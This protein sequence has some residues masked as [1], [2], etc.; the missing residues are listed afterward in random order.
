MQTPST[1]HHYNLHSSEIEGR[2]SRSPSAVHADQQPPQ[3]RWNS[4]PSGCCQFIRLFTFCSR[5]VCGVR[6][7]AART[8]CICCCCC[9]RCESTSAGASSRRCARRWRSSRIRCSGPTSATTSTTTRPASISSTAIRTCSGTCW[10]IIARDTC[11][12][13]ATS[14]SQLSRKRWRSL[15]F[16]RTSSATA[17]T[18]SIET[19]G[20]RILNDS[21]T[22]RLNERMNERM[23]WV[24]ATLDG[25]FRR[26]RWLHC[27]REANDYATDQIA[28]VKWDLVIVSFIHRPKDWRDF[29]VDS[30][31]WISSSI[32]VRLKLSKQCESFPITL[33]RAFIAHYVVT[34]LYNEVTTMNRPMFGP[35]Y[36][37]IYDLIRQRHVSKVGGLYWWIFAPVL[38]MLFIFTIIICQDSSP[39]SQIIYTKIT[40]YPI[41]FIFADSIGWHRLL[42]FH[43]SLW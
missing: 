11:I 41:K 10:P 2:R 21:P 30:R 26:W 9:C 13:R 7:L 38:A 4:A 27:E 20:G 16:S 18:R 32:S 43:F 22:T 42:L 3:S 35:M 36:G 8:R 19:G 37:P 25:C 24:N 5:N 6:P 28:D 40:C 14:A 1:F 23:E 39:K 12:T 29:L 15:A 34:R 17:A 31:S 33:A